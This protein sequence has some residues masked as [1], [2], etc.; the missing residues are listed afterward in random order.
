MGRKAAEFAES[1]VP[2]GIQ[3]KTINYRWPQQDNM[4][5]KKKLKRKRIILWVWRTDLV[6]ILRRWALLGAA[7]LL[8][9]TNGHNRMVAPSMLC[10]LMGYHLASFWAY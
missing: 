2:N 4:Q 9:G 1:S 8:T 6:Q 5:K 10:L 7:F 3:R